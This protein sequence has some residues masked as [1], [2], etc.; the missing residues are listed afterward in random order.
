MKK[1]LRTFAIAALA[2][3]LVASAQFKVETVWSNVVKDGVANPIPGPDGGWGS[4]TATNNGG[5][6]VCR[7][8]VGKDGKVL[9][10]DHKANAI[11]AWDGTTMTTYAELPAV[12]VTDWSGNQNEEGTKWNGTAV[13]TDDAGNVIY[14]YCFIN[15]DKSL[16]YWGVIAADG[17]ITDVD[18][19]TPLADLGQHGRLDMIGHIVGDV[20][21]EKGGIGYATTQ[22]SDNVIMFHFKGDGT[23]VTSLTAKSF[24]VEGLASDGLFVPSAKYLTVDEILA[25]STPEA[26]FYVPMGD[27][28]AATVAEGTLA[29]GSEVLTGYGNRQYNLSATFELGGKKYIVRNYVDE[30][31]PEFMTVWKGVMTFGIFDLESG[32]CVATWMGSDYTNA[33]GMGNVNAE[34][35][36]EN[37][38]NIYMFVCTGTADAASG[39]TPGAYAAMVK[40]TLSDEEP[41]VP[42]FEGDGTA[43]NPYKIATAEDLCNAYRVVNGLGCDVYFEQTADIDMAGVK[44]YHAI[45][46]YDGNY[47]AVIHYDGKNHLITNFAPENKP[48]GKVEGTD[49]KGVAETDYYYCTS[50]FGVASGEISNLGVINANCVTD[51][52]AGILAGYAGHSSATPLILDNVFVT[53]TVVGTGGYTGGFF[54]TTGNI[55]TMTNCF[56]N[57][58]VNGAKFPAG[59]IG[60]ASNDINLERVYTA[61]TVEG[62]DAYLVMGTNKSPEFNGWQV[63]AFNTGADAAIAPAFEVL[64][65]EVEVATEETKDTLIDDVKNWKG[66]S[67][68]S[69]IL[70]LPA[71]EWV[72]N[73]A[74]IANVAVDNE[75]APVEY[76]NLQG[77]R[78]NQP[79]AGSI[80]IMKQGTKTS[81]FI[82]R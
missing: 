69:T 26:E 16:Q 48:W 19:S 3:P 21:S 34:V 75:N 57:V 68:T 50:V 56:A 42:T 35:V 22:K 80:V 11:V 41:F 47:A 37:T 49:W 65:A 63:A 77:I 4:P 10:N 7:F 64:D 40:V 1:T 45:A 39:T 33:Y 38:V 67:A 9:M 66:Y 53:G 24:G 71:L 20:N 43:A 8:A 54:G 51:H 18:L 28:G 81:K 44:E 14:D 62:P 2:M 60:R 52:G 78:V 27:K 15:A 5:K 76:Y 17:T 72:P 23:K 12:T 58:N 13:T 73:E 30:T 36:D 74:G 55:V 79:A 70:G 29:S 82:V 31:A 6:T 25:S 46:G 61:G 59:L 32:E